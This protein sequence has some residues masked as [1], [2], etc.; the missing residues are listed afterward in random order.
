MN[1]TSGSLFSI[2]VLENGVPAKQPL[3]KIRQIV[4]DALIPS[5]TGSA[6]LMAAP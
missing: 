4:N 2:S 3:H 6:R 5:S 1:D